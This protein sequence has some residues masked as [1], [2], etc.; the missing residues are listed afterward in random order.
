MD[1]Y[2]NYTREFKYMVYFISPTL[3]VQVRMYHELPS[4]QQRSI[5]YLTQMDS[6]LHWLPL[7][8]VCLQVWGT[9]RFF[10]YVTRS[11]LIHN[12]VV[13]ALHVS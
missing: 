4:E 9:L 1:L 10:L 2:F 13:L 6:K 5:S 3:V 8:Y 7:I 11:P 12:Q